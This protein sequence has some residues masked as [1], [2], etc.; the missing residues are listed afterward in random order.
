LRSKKRAWEW[1]EKRQPWAEAELR[2]A[3]KKKTRKRKRNAKKTKKKSLNHRSS[4]RRGKVAL[5]KKTKG[6]KGIFLKRS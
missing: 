5:S 2:W 1:G 3:E 4:M 6:E